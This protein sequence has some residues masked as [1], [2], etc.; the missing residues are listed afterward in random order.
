H[1]LRARRSR[2]QL[3]DLQRFVADRALRGARAPLP[4]PRILDRREPEDGLQGH[5][6]AGGGVGGGGVDAPLASSGEASIAGVVVYTM[7]CI[8]ELKK[9]HSLSE[10]PKPPLAASR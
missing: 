2:S 9:G 1:V 8:L 10:R 4:I 7:W 3:R 5:F 6:S